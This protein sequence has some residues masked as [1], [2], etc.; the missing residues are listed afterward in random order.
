MIRKCGLTASVQERIETINEIIDW[1]N[2][3]DEKIVDN[4]KFKN[5]K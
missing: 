4:A 2:K 1:I 3:A 5:I